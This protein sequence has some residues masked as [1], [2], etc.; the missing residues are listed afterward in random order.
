MAA[1]RYNRMREVTGLE[2]ELHQAAHSMQDWESSQKV[3]GLYMRGLRGKEEALGAK[4][5][6]ILDTVHG[7]GNLYRDQGDVTKDKEMYERAANGYRDV[8]ADREADLT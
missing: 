6:S 7:L 2:P 4:Y 8:E 1:R 5:T 3:K